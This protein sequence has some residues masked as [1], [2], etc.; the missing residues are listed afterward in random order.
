MSFILVFSFM[1]AFC[2]IYAVFSIVFEEKM[3]M[4][5]RISKISQYDSNLSKYADEALQSSFIDRILKPMLSW[6]SLITQKL[7]PMRKKDF[8]EKKLIQA[9]GFWNLS[10][11]EFISL[12]YTVIGIITVVIIFFNYIQHSGYLT[13]I[14]SITIGIIFTRI[15]MD[16]I[17]KIKIKERQKQVV[18]ALPDVLD[19]LTVSVEAGLGFDAAIQKVVQKITGPLSEEFGKTLQEMKMGKPRREALR[20]LADK[21]GVNDLNTF[22][23]AIIQADLLGVSIGNVLRIQSKQMRLIRKQR[24]EEKA[25]KAPIKMLIPMVLFIFPAIFIVLLGPAAIQVIENFKV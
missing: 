4:F 20:D 3:H 14:F 17:L 24:I 5:L 6:G 19:L 23:G 8:L 21:M 9:G 22:V 15:F 7:T 12:N 16:M 18:K 2:A 13:Y 25:M 11:N 10:V 1:F